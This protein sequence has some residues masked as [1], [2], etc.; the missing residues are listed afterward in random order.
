MCLPEK[1]EGDLAIPTTDGIVA[2]WGVTRALRH[3]ELPKRDD[4][5]IVLRR[6]CFHHSERP[7]LFE[8]NGTSLQLNDDIL[9]G[10]W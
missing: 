2:G 9:C 1:D 10:G 6:N 7:G 3:G 4:I 5:S 8:Q